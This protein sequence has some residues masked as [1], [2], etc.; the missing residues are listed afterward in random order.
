MKRQGY[1]LVTVVLILALIGA[2]MLLLADASDS[3]SFTSH[4]AQ[5]QACKRNL[6][7][8]GLAW[9]DRNAAQSGQ[10]LA[11]G[12]ELDAKDLLGRQL[13]VALTPEGKYEITTESRSGRMTVK[14]S[15]VF[16]PPAGAEPGK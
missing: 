15:E 6:T 9:L 3:L 2:A 7:A 1:A 11:K 14:D 16:A 12:I 10:E 5:V 8:S 13:K 4:Q